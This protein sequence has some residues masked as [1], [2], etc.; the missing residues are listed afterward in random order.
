MSGIDNII[1]MIN[2]KTAEKEKEILGEAETHKAQKMSEAKKMATEIADS[3]TSKAEAESRAEIGRYEASAKLK[4]K[5]QLLEAK[6]K[7]IEEV[8]A[9]AMK[10]LEDIVGKKAYEKTLERLAIDAAAPLEETELDIV[11]PKGHAKHITVKTVEAAVT[12]KSGKKTNISVSKETVRATGGAIVRNKDNTRWV[13]NTFE[14]RFER[15][16]SAIRGK[17]SDIL[18]SSDKKEK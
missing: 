3:I 11:L 9:S 10:H 13:D 7:L 4:S 18:F 14:A 12:K 1:E 5:Y 17:I 8:L 15:L 16:E 6:E 2:T